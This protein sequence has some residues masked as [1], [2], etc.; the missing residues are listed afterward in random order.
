MGNFQNICKHRAYQY[1]RLPLLFPARPRD[2]KKKDN[3][4][5]PRR[6]PC[7]LTMPD[8]FPQ[9]NEL[10]PGVYLINGDV[11]GR[12][13]A[14]PLLRGD[15]QSI[16]MDTGC[17]SDVERLIIPALRELSLAPADI[18]YIINTHCDLDHQGG[19]AAMKRITP[20]ALLGCGREDA[21]QIADPEVIFARRYDAYRAKHHH[22][23][24]ADVRDWIMDSLGEAQP[25]DVTYDGGETIDL[26]PDWSVQVLKLPGHSRGHVAVW[27]ERNR[28]LL[29]GDAI[30]GDVYL[31]FEGEPALCPTYLHVRDYLETIRK[32]ETMQPEL[33]SG[34]HWQV[35]RGAEVLEFCRQSR[36]FVERAET[37]ILEAISQS[38]KGLS[39]TELCFGVGPKLGDWPQEINHELCYA[40]NGH[41]E[42]LVQRGLIREVLGDGPAV[43]TSAN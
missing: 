37:A 5:I 3:R 31:N 10:H 7:H 38:A 34:C 13:L 17:A 26:S 24:D 16:L 23:Y 15:D 25:V 20:R 4:E 41:L 22:F 6:I 14:L 36:A 43:Y 28:T 18:T 27:D 40:F 33:Y 2:A 1:P 8:T 30:H 19:N 21:E 11:G 42:D 12:P 29:A 9:I 32:I 35:F 39:L